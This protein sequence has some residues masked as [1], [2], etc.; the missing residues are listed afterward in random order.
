MEWKQKILERITPGEEERAHILTIANEVMARLK[1]KGL[2]A[3]LTGSQAKGT[4]L[5][6]ATDVDIFVLLPTNTP[7]SSF[8][9]TVM[10][11]KEFF[12]DVEHE[13]AYAHHP[14]LRIYYKGLR[15]DLVPAYD[16]A[17]V[18]EAKS[19]VDRTIFHTAYVQK[20]LDEKGR[21]EVRLLK[22]F[23]KANALYGAEI[24]VAGFSGYLCELMVIKFGSFEEVMKA[25]SEY[26]P[27]EVWTLGEVG[28][29]FSDAM[30]FVDPVD[31]KRNVA[32]AVS[33]ET[34]ARTKALAKLW[35]KSERKVEY[36]K[37]TTSYRPKELAPIYALEFS[38]GKESKDILW[39]KV[40]KEFRKL[41]QKAMQEGIYINLV[42]C[43]EKEREGVVFFLSSEPS[44]GYY[45]HQGP[46]LI[47]GEHLIRFLEKH[48]AVLW[49]GHS[50]LTLRPYR[51][52][53]VEDLIAKEGFFSFLPH[54]LL[55]NEKT[56][57]HE[58]AP[59]MLIALMPTLAEKGLREWE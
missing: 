43:E 11:M 20:H 10:K 40:K 29:H 38:F 3:Q 16:I 35:L 4:A 12:A 2:K 23:F 27:G 36:F 33:M 39:G 44:S 22:A 49:E 15:I 21:E 1:T 7:Y 26:R 41:K 56:L 45:R 5:K 54:R 34:L 25:L 17:R 9:D 14:Y 57:E 8:P 53:T 58:L 55:K 52:K 46:S 59:K 30:V 48:E 18:E 13:I 28:K 6:G 50:A 24:R 19:P 47:Q 51:I 31:P 42:L 32:A 37:P